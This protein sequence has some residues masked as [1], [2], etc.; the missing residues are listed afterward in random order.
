MNGISGE[1]AKTDAYLLSLR[2]ILSEPIDRTEN[3]ALRS[4]E[5]LSREPSSLGCAAVSRNCGAEFRAAPVELLAENIKLMIKEMADAGKY[6]T[7]SGR[8]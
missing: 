2:A 6:P 5:S 7:V 1:S 8:A 3:R 4:D